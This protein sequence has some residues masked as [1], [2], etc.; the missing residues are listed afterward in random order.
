MPIS[1]SGFILKTAS[2]VREEIKQQYQ[3]SFG[4][5][6]QVDNSN[7]VISQFYEQDVRQ[8]ILNETTLSEAYA[9]LFIDTAEGQQLDFLGQ[10][11]NIDR[12]L[13]TGSTCTLRFIGD[14]G[15]VVP[16]G[17]RVS[18]SI[19]PV[20]IFETLREVQIGVVGFVD[21]EAQ[22]LSGGVQTN[23]N[24]GQINNIINPLAGLSSVENITPSTGGGEAETDEEYRTRY[25]NLTSMVG[26]FANFRKRMLQI[27][28]VSFIDII[29]NT[30]LFPLYDI[31]A[32][33]V[34]FLIEGGTATEIGQ[35]FADLGAMPFRTFGQEKV[36]V[37][38]SADRS[39]DYYFTRP[40]SV[41]VNSIEV[42]IQKITADPLTTLFLNDFKNQI[43]AYINSIPTARRVSDIEVVAGTQSSLLKNFP[44]DWNNIEN[45]TMRF[46]TDNQEGSSITM[47]YYEK[48]FTT[49]EAISID[50]VI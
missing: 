3:N 6:V 15:T 32:L 11:A 13:S 9:S 20:I 34:T 45:I 30:T 21:V 22:S 37:I 2:E 36:T 1:K 29:E 27:Q 40:A 49:L 28:G 14:F 43:V 24:I 19:A 23:L 26:N 33:A 5:D 41:E 25:K 10:N 50:E 17:F 46:T 18:K 12:I 4:T 38:N 31:P 16:E 35:A 48:P 8:F 44:E 39:V 47:S 7:A 42:F